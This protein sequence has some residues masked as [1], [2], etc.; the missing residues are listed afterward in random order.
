[1]TESTY[2][3]ARASHDPRSSAA[4][5]PAATT[6]RLHE[7]GRP[8]PAAGDEVAW[9]R[10]HALRR[11]LATLDAR[12]AIAF[13]EAQLAPLAAY[14]LEHGTT[15]ERVLELALDHEDRAT[16]ARAAFMHRN[17]FRRQLG[18]ARELLEADLDAPEERLA[19]HVALKLRRLVGRAPS[20]RCAVHRPA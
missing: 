9:A 14:D 7:V 6:A 2:L 15:L 16:A 10:D 13:V 11:L 20:G 18:K 5:P 1:M 4:D 3:R 8:R 12:S 19:V 17:T